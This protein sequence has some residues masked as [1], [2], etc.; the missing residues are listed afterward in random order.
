[1]IMIEKDEFF[2]QMRSKVEA[3]KAEKKR[4]LVEVERMVRENQDNLRQKQKIIDTTKGIIDDIRGTN[5]NLMELLSNKQTE[6]DGLK[7]DLADRDVQ[8]VKL[9]EKVSEN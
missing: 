8:I 9:K 3:L 4:L 5:D 1:M 7:K 2:V 6:V